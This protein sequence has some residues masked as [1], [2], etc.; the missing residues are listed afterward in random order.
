MKEYLEQ[1][2]DQLRKSHEELLEKLM[3][4]QQSSPILTFIKE[5]LVDIES[6]LSKIEKGEFGKC[7]ISGELLPAEFLFILPT[8]KSNR[9]LE[10]LQKF[11]RKP[12]YS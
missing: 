5:E 9:D 4:C 10:K 8:V 2:Q 11:Y 12:L 3:T 1:I 7:E 6:T